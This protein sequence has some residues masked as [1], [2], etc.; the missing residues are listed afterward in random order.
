M[1]NYK[2][3]ESISFCS[4][5]TFHFII[6][7]LPIFH[8]VLLVERFEEQRTK[9][10]SCLPEIDFISPSISFLPFRDNTLSGSHTDEGP[11]PFRLH[12]L[13]KSFWGEGI[14][15]GDQSCNFGR[16]IVIVVTT[17]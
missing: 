3:C 13:S 12:M 17:T 10:Y 6:S 11:V 2:H 5:S 15:F 8:A 16:G 14:S 1:R 7:V 9:I 4:V